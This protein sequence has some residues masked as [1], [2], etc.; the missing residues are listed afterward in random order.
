MTT[1]IFEQVASLDYASVPIGHH[2]QWRAA[3]DNLDE[4]GWSERTTWNVSCMLSVR[5]GNPERLKQILNVA[6]NSVAAH[7]VTVVVFIEG[8]K[9]NNS[10]KKT[11]PSTLDL[12]DARA[13]LSKGW[14]L[15]DGV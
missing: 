9:K 2:E 15:M 8:D 3:F 5:K 13:E 6:I 1:G 4:R 14:H 12:K 7:G 10:I 11:V